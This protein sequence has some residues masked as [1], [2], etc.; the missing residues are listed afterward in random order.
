MEKIKILIFDKNK[1]YKDAISYLLKDKRKIKSVFSISQYEH[2]ISVLEKFYPDMVLIN[3]LKM[4]TKELENLVKAIKT[5]NKRT[6]IFVLQNDKKAFNKNTD[7]YVDLIIPISKDYNYLYSMIKKHVNK[8]VEETIKEFSVNYKFQNLTDREMD[9]MK[10][11]SKGMSN[12]KISA[13]LLITERTV[14]NHVSSILK[15]MSVND[16][17][18]ALI[19]SLKMGIVDLD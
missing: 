4:G 8:N 19:K 17:T 15:K 5:I 2:V 12:K 14:K 7:R 1:L 10:L 3:S 9:V 13:E 11:I 18:Q 6:N 16:R